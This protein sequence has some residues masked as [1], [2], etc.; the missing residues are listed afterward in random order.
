MIK[1]IYGCDW[2]KV[3]VYPDSGERHLKEFRERH[4]DCDPRPIAT[5][6]DNN[7]PGSAVI[8]ELPPHTTLSVGAKYRLVLV[9]PAGDK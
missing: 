3:A 8:M 1:K 4:K 9:E 6:I 5:V 7:Q 2:C